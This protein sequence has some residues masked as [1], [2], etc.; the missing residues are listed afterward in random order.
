MY[1]TVSTSKR[2]F[3]ADRVSGI[4]GTT[5]TLSIILEIIRHGNT[6]QPYTFPF[7]GQTIDCTQET[8]TEWIDAAAYAAVS[9]RIATAVQKNGMRYFLVLRRKSTAAANALQSSAWRLLPQLAIADPDELVRLYGQWMRRYIQ[10]YSLGAVTFLYEQILSDRL[11]QHL[12]KETGDVGAVLQYL[13]QTPFRSFMQQE[14]ALLSSI[15]HAKK[16]EQQRLV[17]KFQQQFFYGRTS[18]AHAPV[19]TE[20]WVLTHARRAARHTESV[21]KR[22]Q[23]RKRLAVAQEHRTLARLLRV[24]GVIR[25]ERKRIN[26]IGSYCMFRF[27]DRAV[28]RARLP[29]A[30]VKRAFWFEY[31]QIARQHAPLLRSLQ[32]RTKASLVLADNTALYLP[33][34]ALREQTIS[35]AGKGVFRGTPASTGIVR[36]RACVVLS[37]KDFRR[38]RAGDILISEMTRPDYLPFMR[39]AGGIVTDEGGLMSHAAIVARELHKPCVVGT[40]NATSTLQDGDRVEVDAEKGIVRKL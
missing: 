18:Y 9:D 21:R 11:A 10:A 37:R 1:P 12:A 39:K 26:L 25:D 36:G 31:P 7:Y 34:I 5:F 2:M 22:R 15:G 16:R 40:K 32:R 35:A 24:S 14:E 30:L 17:Q 8:S 4:E 20:S 27:L 6:Y 13:L 23:A 29:A 38:F 19:V 33:R 28:Q 3:A